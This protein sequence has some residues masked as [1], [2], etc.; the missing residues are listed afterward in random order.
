MSPARQGGGGHI[1][2]VRSA[3]LVMRDSWCVTREASHIRFHAISRERLVRFTSNLV[4]GSLMGRGRFF[5]KTGT[6]CWC[7]VPP[8][9]AIWK[10]FLCDN[11]RTLETIHFKFGLWITHGQRK[12]HFENWHQVVPFESGH[13][14]TF[15]GTRWCWLSLRRGTLHT[16]VCFL[17]YKWNN[18]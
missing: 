14:W 9:G 3:W 2:F 10:R 17:V 13:R 15:F 7:Q 12:V 16:L 11:S 18:A 8:D 6:R 4:C 1:V 5:P